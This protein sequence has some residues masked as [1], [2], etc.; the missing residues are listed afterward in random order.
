MVTVN[1]DVPSIVGTSLVGEFERVRSV[2]GFTDG[3]LAGL[4]RAGV[5]ASFAPEGSKA[6][7]RAGIDA[8]LGSGERAGG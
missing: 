2:F 4:A 5:D 8:W 7:W 6:R 3:A 1:A